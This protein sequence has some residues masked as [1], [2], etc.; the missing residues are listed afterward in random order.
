MYIRIQKYYF[1]PQC[2]VAEN[3]IFVLR[4]ARVV[5]TRSK[6]DILNNY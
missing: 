2:I 5:V 1:S 6:I 4:N 3:L